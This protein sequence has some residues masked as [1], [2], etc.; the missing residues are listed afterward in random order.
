MK[1]KFLS[2][3]L[4]AA[5]SVSMFA[6]CGKGAEKKEKNAAAK[7]ETKTERGN[8]HVFRSVFCMTGMPSVC[9]E[10]PQGA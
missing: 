6:G 8:D 7:N 5:L 10:S 3:F 1:K 9:G 4:V 2:L